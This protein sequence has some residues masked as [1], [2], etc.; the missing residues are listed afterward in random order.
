MSAVLKYCSV[1]GGLQRFENNN[2]S[3]EH[4][5][6]KSSNRCWQRLTYQKSSAIA[7]SLH[8]CVKH[9]QRRRLSNKEFQNGA[10]SEKTFITIRASPE[11]HI[12]PADSGGGGEWGE[13]SPL[14]TQALAHIGLKGTKTASEMGH[15]KQ[16]GSQHGSCKTGV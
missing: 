3:Q 7:P 6:I 8:A 14:G 9:I 1:Q 2:I 11:E 16:P 4:V 12:I 5:E 10:I 15:G 13:G